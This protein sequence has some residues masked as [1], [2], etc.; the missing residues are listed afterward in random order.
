MNNDVEK[1]RKIWNETA[2]QYCKYKRGLG[3]SKVNNI[4][5]GGEERA[6]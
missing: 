3:E 5:V 4:G 6:D 1:M 2:R